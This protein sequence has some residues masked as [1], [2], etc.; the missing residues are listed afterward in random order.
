MLTRVTR[1]E[2]VEVAPRDGLQNEARSLSTATKLELVERA[3]AAGRGG[4]RSRRSC[5]RSR[6]PQMADAEA[7][8][9]GLA[10]AP[11]VEYSALVLNERG[12]D[13]ALAAGVDAVNTVV[14]ATETFSERNQGMSVDEA[15]RGRPEHAGARRRR[16]RAVHRDD[17]G[18]LRMP[19]RGRGRARAARRGRRAGRRD[20]PG[21]DRARRHDRRRGSE[22]RR[23]APRDRPVASISTSP[24]AAPLPQHAEHGHRERRRG[25]AVR[26]RRCS[27]P[28]SPG[29]AAV[30]SPPR[31]PGTSRRRTSST[32]SRRMG[33]ETGIELE[34]AIEAAR[35]LAGG[36]GDRACRDGGAGRRIPVS[37]CASRAG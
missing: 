16:R 29:S 22:R 19:V 8:V 15:V 10:A 13:R 21:R 26:R 17:L 18:R 35:W 24:L 9:A 7:V 34:A 33:Y 14:S 5:T 2:I 12:Y 23:G 3:R 36:L 1:V 11:G 25:C 31:R 28:P 27:T 37:P 4:S 32:R 6:V 20:R 30:L